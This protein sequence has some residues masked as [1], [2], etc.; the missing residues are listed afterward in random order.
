MVTLHQSYTIVARLPV[1]PKSVQ[2]GVLV[3]I[4]CLRWV[5]LVM[6]L[7]IWSVFVICTMYTYVRLFLTV[8]FFILLLTASQVFLL[9]QN[10][11]LS[12][13]V[14][15]RKFLRYL[16]SRVSASWGR[17]CLSSRRISASLSSSRR[18]LTSLCP[19]NP[20]APV[21]TH[22][23]PLRDMTGRYSLCI[24]IVQTVSSTLFSSQAFSVA[25]LNLWPVSL[26]SISLFSLLSLLAFLHSFDLTKSPWDSKR[27]TRYVVKVKRVLQQLSVQQSTS[28]I[29]FIHLSLSRLPF[30]P[31]ENVL[32][33]NNNNKNTFIA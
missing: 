30:L 29:S 2:T 31:S 16:P 23:S 27:R 19:R 1:Y 32:E 21:T 33:K 24:T 13:K 22:T 25:F 3:Y 15:Q 7:Y 17:T 8:L 6:T 11:E 9:A 26:W 14:A 10:T 4:T 28:V 12:N 5:H 18:S 20:L